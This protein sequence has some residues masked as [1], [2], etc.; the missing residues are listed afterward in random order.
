ML[1][2]YIID[3]IQIFFKTCKYDFRIK[4][5]KGIIGAW[6]PKGVLGIFTSKLM[7][8]NNFLQICR[9]EYMHLRGFLHRDIKPDNFL[10]GL[11]RRASQVRAIHAHLL[12]QLDLQL[13]SLWKLF[14]S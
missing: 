4:I 9:V 1:V 7:Y 6:E 8:L 3:Y 2:G 14:V 12:V 5:N 11:G 13:S 10:M